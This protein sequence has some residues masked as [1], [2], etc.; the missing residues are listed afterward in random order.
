MIPDS[1]SEFR[2][3]FPISDSACDLITFVM[4]FFYFYGA[5]LFSYTKQ[6][7]VLVD[8]VV[9]CEMKQ[10]IIAS[11]CMLFRVIGRCDELPSIV[12]TSRYGK[13]DCH[14]RIGIFLI[15]IESRSI[16]TGFNFCKHYRFKFYQSTLQLTNNSHKCNPFVSSS[17]TSPTL[18]RATRP[19]PMPRRNTVKPS[20]W[21]NSR[22]SMSRRH[23]KPTQS[24]L[25]CQ[26]QNP[27]ST[28]I[29]N[30]I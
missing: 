8:N 15:R 16:N 5:N 25:R 22:R 4:H 26:S 1:S 20:P 19:I 11:S 29:I 28:N 30:K 9:Q 3:R 12:S 10:T 14:F 23:R 7:V 24:A 18:P 17:T 27:P 21:S 2:R 6:S 13:F